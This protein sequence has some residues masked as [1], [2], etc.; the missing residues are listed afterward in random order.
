MNLSEIAEFIVFMFFS[1]FLM[2]AASVFP[3]MFQI[4]NLQPSAGEPE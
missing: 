2:F 1:T 4:R 3:A